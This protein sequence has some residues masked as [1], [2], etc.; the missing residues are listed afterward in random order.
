[1][2]PTT[3]PNVII[4][5]SDEH[6]YKYTGCY[7][8]KL[9]KTP[10]ID[11]L[12]REG[13]RFDNFF[14]TY[15]LCCPTRASLLTGEYTFKNNVLNNRRPL[16]K[17]LPSLVQ[18][19]VQNDYSTYYVGKWHVPGAE[20]SEMG[21]QDVEYV[22]KTGWGREIP[23]YMDALKEA[24]VNVLSDKEYQKIADGK[25]LR[26][27]PYNVANLT[28]E[29]H[30]QDMEMSCGISSKD[31]ELYSDCWFTT[32][33]IDKIKQASEQE[34][35]FLSVCSWKAPHWPM[36]VPEK[37]ANMYNPED[38]VLPESF[39]DTMEDAPACIRED[40]QNTTRVDH[41][42]EYGWKKMI[43]Y[44]MGMITLIDDQVGRVVQTVK[45]LGIADNT[46]I[47]YL[48]D[49]GDQ[50]GAH[51]LMEKRV[52]YE[53]SIHIPLV[54]SNPAINNSNPV[55]TD[56]AT[57]LDVF[58]TLQELCG[59]DVTENIAGKSIAKAMTGDYLPG[60]DFIVTENYYYTKNYTSNDNNNIVAQNKIPLLELVDNGIKYSRTI[61]THRWKY[62]FYTNDQDELFD[63]GV[64]PNEMVNLAVDSQYAD[65]VKSFRFKLTGWLREHKD[66]FAE[67]LI[68]LMD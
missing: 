14:T 29:E 66:P 24:G 64:D 59:L 28:L 43:A 5:F 49:H 46:I 41:L 57:V 18:P 10:H 23:E 39:N 16:N 40:R 4:L 34:Q 44:Y 36:I 1:M 31:E 63:L 12:A 65:L 55:V 30:L 11:R 51:N 17:E 54:L 8:D 3:K 38:I 67:Q 62:T 37:Y 60:R 22:S 27:L 6:N 42:D 50:M 56:L 35:P 33:L 45:D 25:G 68:S 52:N 15:P 53:E 7:G 21:F 9:T 26:Y 48:S 47:V 19:F 32:K 2:K 20:A 13:S 58:P 61:R